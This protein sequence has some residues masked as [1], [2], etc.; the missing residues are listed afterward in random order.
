MKVLIRYF[1]ES[2]KYYCDGYYE[3]NIE[4]LHDWLVFA[5]VRRFNE[6]ENLPGLSSGRWDGYALVQTNDGVPAILD[7]SKNK[8]CT[9]C[10]L[11]LC[12]DGTGGFIPCTI[13]GRE[14]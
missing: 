5:E 9:F 7:F 3:T 1:K 6:L 4:Y 13:C 14:S 11:G 2:G 12:P 8:R 10:E